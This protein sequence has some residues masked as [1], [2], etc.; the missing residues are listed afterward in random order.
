MPLLLNISLKLYTPFPIGQNLITRPSLVSWDTG[1]CSLYPWWPN[2]KE[3]TDIGGN[4]RFLPLYLSY[5]PL[6][7]YIS[8]H[9]AHL[10]SEWLGLICPRLSGCLHWSPMFQVPPSTLQP[11]IIDKQTGMIVTLCYLYLGSYQTLGSLRNRTVSPLPLHPQ[12]LA[13][14]STD[15]MHSKNSNIHIVPFMYQKLF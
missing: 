15:N 3:I 7:S 6:R 13:Q 14:C 11:P 10:Q 5:F 12:F 2:A 1:E 4:K 9:L 8:S